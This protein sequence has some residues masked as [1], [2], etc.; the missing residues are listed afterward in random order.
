MTINTPFSVSAAIKAGWNLAK[1]NWVILV[2]MTLSYLI[3]DLIITFVSGSNPIGS[4]ITIII[5]VLYSASYYQMLLRAVDDEE[6][7]LSD[8][9]V[10]LQKI[11]PFTLTYLLTAII[12]IVSICLFILPAFWVIPR[13]VFAPYLILDRPELGPI[14][15]IKESFR[16]TKTKWAPMLGFLIVAALINLVGVI[17]LFVGVFY[18]TVVTALATVAA[19]RMLQNDA[20]W[21]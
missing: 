10:A 16:I 17:C 1:K 11:V 6:P 5:S 20:T 14:G 13:I 21:E 2:G 12:G 19:M 8:I 15:A 3:I 9:S 4:I 18:T 7:T